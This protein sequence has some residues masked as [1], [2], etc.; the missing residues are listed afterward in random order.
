MTSR[1]A[2]LLVDPFPVIDY[3]KYKVRLTYK[4]PGTEVITSSHEVEMNYSRSR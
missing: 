1:F 3:G 2:A 4:I